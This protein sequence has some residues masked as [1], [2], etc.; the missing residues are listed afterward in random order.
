[1]AIGLSSSLLVWGYVC[2]YLQV[3]RHTGSS[4]ILFLWFFVPY[5]TVSYNSFPKLFVFSFSFRKDPLSGLWHYTCTELDL[6]RCGFLKILITLT[7]TYGRIFKQGSPTDLEQCY[8][9]LPCMQITF[10]SCGKCD[11]TQS[12]YKNVD[13]P[14]VFKCPRLPRIGSHKC[15]CMFSFKQITKYSWLQWV[16]P[17]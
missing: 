12:W 2:T 7:K 6:H 15:T 1:M 8:G 14:E 4:P 16:L 9:K 5:D 17:F 3:I 13:R 10:M 11:N